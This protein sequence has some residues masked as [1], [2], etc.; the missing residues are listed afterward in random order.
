VLDEQVKQIN[1]K[2]SIGSKGY[3]VDITNEDAVRANCIEVTKVFGRIDGLVNNAAN[4]P[5]VENA[6]EKN[7]SRLEYFPLL[8]WENDLA[9]GLKGSFICIKYYGFEISKNPFGGSI[10]NISSDLGVIAPD[11]RLYK[12]DGLNEEQQPVKPITYSVVKTGLIGMTKYVAT[13]W[14]DK[15]VRCNALCPGGV[16]NNQN[17]DFLKAVSFRI[18]MGR[19]ARPDEYRGAL[20]FLLSEASSYMTGAVLSVDGGR[21]AW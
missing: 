14:A 8:T 4:N 10:V 13:Y 18:P 7:F 21:T 16:E 3:A 17:A 9:V 12:I 5:K 20:L 19:M 11:Q 15:G 1:L 2:F 6:A